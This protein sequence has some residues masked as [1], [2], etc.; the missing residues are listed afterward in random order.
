MPELPSTGG[1][2]W[3]SIPEVNSWH[4]LLKEDG[5]HSQFRKSIPNFKSKVKELT[6]RIE[7]QFLPLLEGN[8]GI[9]NSI[10]KVNSSS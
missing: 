8:S 4:Y 2:N 5:I 1:W 10:P 3:S 7:Y 9:G 6:S